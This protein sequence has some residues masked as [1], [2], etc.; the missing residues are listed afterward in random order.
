MNTSSKTAHHRKAREAEALRSN[1]QRR[2]EQL[3]AR[4][5]LAQEKLHPSS[6]TPME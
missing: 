6:L 4:K 2:K 1:L 3:K 5:I